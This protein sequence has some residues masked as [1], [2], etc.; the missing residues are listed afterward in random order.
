MPEKP[1][2]LTK[3]QL[4][5]VYNRGVKKM[6][7]FKEKKDYER[8]VQR[9]NRYGGRYM[10][11]VVAYCLMPNHF[12]FILKETK[13]ATKKNLANISKFLQVLQTSYAK[14]FLKKY[15]FSGH[16]FQGKFQSKHVY[17][18]EYF[19]TLST[20]ILNNPIKKNLVNE[21]QKWPYLKVAPL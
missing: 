13:T 15:S 12:H 9:I 7:I 19:D 11:S 10:V 18:D 5:H 3:G 2:Y 20:Y 8:F 16:V 1:R 14:Y 17:S 6:N 4:Y 21:P